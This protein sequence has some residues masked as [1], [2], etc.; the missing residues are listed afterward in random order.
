MSHGAQQAFARAAGLPVFG[1]L[2]RNP[3][4]TLALLTAILAGLAPQAKIFVGTADL[5]LVA[6]LLYLGSGLGLLIVLLVRAGFGI[7]VGR[8]PL[9]RAEWPWMLGST[10]VSGIIAPVLLMLG[11]EFTHASTAALLF[12]LEGLSTMALAWLLF[13]ERFEHRLFLGALL[14]LAGCG[15]LTWRGGPAGF[16]LGA[17]M[18]V[19]AC[20]FWGL[21]N[22]M[23]RKLMGADPIQVTMVKGLIGGAVNIVLAFARGAAMPS[24]GA[25]LGACGVG[26]LAYGLSFVCFILSLRHM[27]TAR[28]GAY[29]STAPFFGAL[30]AILIFSEPITPRFLGAAALMAAGVWLYRT[31]NAVLP[32]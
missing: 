3:G 12:N 17:V 24:L 9:N 23:T 7:P 13:R 16:D 10:L 14:V 20:L 27:G 18:I 2:T 1:W 29:L 31:K 28:T 8:S 30:F 22:V 4:P 21:G 6:G 32:E 15:L 25:T 11:L 26:F 19:A 5:W